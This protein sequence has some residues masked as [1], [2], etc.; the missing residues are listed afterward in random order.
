MD[1]SFF[2]FFFLLFYFL[3][4]LGFLECTNQQHVS[5]VTVPEKSVVFTYL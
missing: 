2:F 1:S 4:L 3:A 5:Y